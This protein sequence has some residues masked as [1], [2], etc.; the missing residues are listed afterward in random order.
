MTASFPHRMLAVLARVVLAMVEDPPALVVNVAVF[1]A[2][3]FAARFLHWLIK[4]TAAWVGRHVASH[5]MSRETDAFDEITRHLGDVFADVDEPTRLPGVARIGPVTPP[6]PR[7]VRRRRR[8]R[9]VRI[10]GRPRMQRHT[11]TP[12]RR[13]S[14]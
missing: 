6:P 7:T 14:Q 5:Q 2:V 1:V 8:I 10:P 11:T 13:R 12:S 4:H 3:V 9:S